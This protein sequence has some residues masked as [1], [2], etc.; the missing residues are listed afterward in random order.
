MNPTLLASIAATPFIVLFFLLVYKRWPAIKAIPLVWALVLVISVTIWK[1]DT[2][3][4]PAS[5]IRGALMALEIMLIIF[6]AVWVLEVL[7]KSG[8]IQSIQD[9][10][11]SISPDARVQ[12]IIIGWLFVS[13]MEGVAG[14]GTPAAMAAPL[15]VAVGFSP[16]LAVSVALISNSVATT[17]GAA[18]TPVLLGLGSMDLERAA[19]EQ[20]GQN[21]AIFHFVASIVV[22]L[23]V[24]MLIVKEHKRKNKKHPE[25]AFSS[26]VPFAIF[27]WLVFGIPYV[28]ATFLI[29]P[30][31]PS[32]IAAIIALCVVSVAAH[33]GF[34][35]PK[36]VISFKKGKKKV[37]SAKEAI[38]S[39]L[40]YVLIVLFLMLTRTIGQLRSALQSIEVSFSSILGSGLGFSYQPLFTPAFFFILSGMI[41]ILLYKQGR[42]EIKES[43]K[44]AFMRVRIATV[45]LIF[46][47]ALVQLFMATENNASGI[48]SM[49]LALAGAVSG[50]FGWAF[51]LVSPLIGAFGS[52]ISG[53][54]TVSNILFGAFQQETALALGMSVPI[55][56]AL[57]AAGGAIG[58]MIAVHN[59][60][61]ANATVGLQNEESTIIRK[62]IVV[63]IIYSVL[64]GIMGL[65]A[66]SIF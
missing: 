54:N 63:A 44:D 36:H 23:A 20:I 24:V 52:F 45:A 48:E 17:F 58:N 61:A 42:T 39:V 43:A 51:P 37:V 35:V 14:F 57:Q 62:T 33:H 11:A 25:R 65:I 41:A 18:G 50:I 26:M 46:A 15:L 12:G 53:S 13:L 21:S 2:I 22:P 3:Y 49:P 10:L 31:L 40:P 38:W 47:L 6:G 19:L 64:V 4:I 28:L 60:L 27:S 16:V 56:L 9:F 34:L 30:E 59:V 7:K 66:I 5:F 55:I 1:V 8:R 32:I 29:G